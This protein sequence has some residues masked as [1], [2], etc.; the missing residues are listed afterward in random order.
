MLKICEK[1]KNLGQ[2]QL[3]QGQTGKLQIFLASFLM[4]TW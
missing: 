4:E 3:G 2:S 1:L